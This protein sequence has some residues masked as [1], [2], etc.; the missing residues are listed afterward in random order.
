MNRRGSLGRLDEQG[1]LEISL[2]QMFGG[3]QARRVLLGILHTRDAEPNVRSGRFDVDA[4]RDIHT[5][6]VQA[7]REAQHAG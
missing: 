2:Q 4:R 3:S 5:T 6:P 1:P 7:A